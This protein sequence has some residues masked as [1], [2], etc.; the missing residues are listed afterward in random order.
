MH[1]GANASAAIQL[2]LAKA[3]GGRRCQLLEH[4][5]QTSASAVR[6]PDIVAFLR[7][8][9]RHLADRKLLIVWDRLQAHRS[10]LV[11]EYVQGQEGAIHLEYLPP[12]AP[13]L[14]P[15]AS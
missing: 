11:R 6:A 9:R 10:R 2:H 14:N 15:I 3:V 12:Y 13:E 1:L 8:L 4:L 5:L 7:A